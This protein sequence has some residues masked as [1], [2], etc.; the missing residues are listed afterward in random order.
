[1]PTLTEKQYLCR[2]IFDIYHKLHVEFSSRRKQYEREL[3]DE[4]KKKTYP[5]IETLKRKVLAQAETLCNNVKELRNLE[6]SS[7]SSSLSSCVYFHDIKVSIKSGVFLPKKAIEE[8][9]DK[10]NK[11][12]PMNNL[13][14]ARR[15][16]QEAE[17]KAML[18]KTGYDKI[19][20]EFIESIDK[21]LK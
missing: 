4:Y 21:L 15:L 20:K 1:M 10:V 11:K 6:H 9:E 3:V 17:D 19:L 8:I 7:S 2:R 5:K 13:D 14:V 12:F 16:Q 18:G